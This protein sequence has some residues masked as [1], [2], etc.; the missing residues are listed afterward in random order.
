MWLMQQDKIRNTLTNCKGMITMAIE[1]ERQ[2]DS[3]DASGWFYTNLA[4]S[5]STGILLL[6]ATCL[7]ARLRRLERIRDKMKSIL[8]TNWAISRG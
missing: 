3:H 2:A 6:L 8:P 5:I 7:W 1:M 4:T